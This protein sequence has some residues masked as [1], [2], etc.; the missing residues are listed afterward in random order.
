MKLL[1][2]VYSSFKSGKVYAYAGEEVEL[3]NKK[4]VVWIVKKPGDINGFPALKC[5]ISEDDSAEITLDD[6]PAAASI[7][8]I[9]NKGVDS[10]SKK[11]TPIEQQTLF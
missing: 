8:I 4:G 3:V 5:D 10:K 9:T 2:T 6:A 11:A 7:N 1:K